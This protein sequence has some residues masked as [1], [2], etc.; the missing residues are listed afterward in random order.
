[1]GALVEGLVQAAVC[2]RNHDDMIV[3]DREAKPKYANRETLR[4]VNGRLQGPLLEAV[5][6]Q[7]AEERWWTSR[8]KA[9]GDRCDAIAIDDKGTLL[10]IEVKPWSATKGIQWAP[11]QARH[12]ANLF[13]EW[14]RQ[15]GHSAARD[16]LIGMINERQR[17]GLLAEAWDVA[18][19]I[20]VQPVVVIGAGSH[21]A[22]RERM[23]QV[24]R[25][26]ADSLQND[27][28]LLIK[29]ARMWGD[30]EDLAC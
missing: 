23:C 27:P 8:P 21:D 6:V 17:M 22:C 2:G 25:R 26:L 13:A 12:Y 3:L 16:V 18:L 14:A 5:K 11:L 7:D 1:M 10:T 20:R 9:L 30:L 24:Q 15:V 28:P 19:P 4:S 29:S